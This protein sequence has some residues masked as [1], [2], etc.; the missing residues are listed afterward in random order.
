VSFYNPKVISQ[1]KL[2]DGFVLAWGIASLSLH[3]SMIWKVPEHI[4]Y[5]VVFGYESL[6][7]Y[8]DRILATMN[9][10]QF[11]KQDVADEPGTGHLRI[12]TVG[13][14]IARLYAPGQLLSQHVRVKSVLEARNPDDLLA[15]LRDQNITYVMMDRNS[16]SP[17]MPG[18]LIAQDEPLDEF[19]ELRHAS[20]N[21]VVYRVPAPDAP[22][23]TSIRH[24]LVLDASFEALGESQ[25]PSSSDGSA[26]TVVAWRA[27][28]SP[29]V[30]DSG[31]LSQTGRTAVKVSA[32]NNFTQYVGSLPP[33]RVFELRYSASAATMPSQGQLQ[34]VWTDSAGQMISANAR[35]F[36]ADKNWGTFRM[37]DS[38]PV[39]AAGAI[40]T[41]TAHVGE[42]WVDDVSFS[43]I[44]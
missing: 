19:L 3:A 20:H 36:D 35:V 41:L 1:K 21:I 34:I 2:V 25:E 30:D 42:V 5:A 11:I 9:S 29:A 44:R 27:L 15:A 28:G 10:L 4:P 24:N 39:G 31:A 16:P 33:D 14:E 23:A 43:G 8:L 38:P 6:D 13:S 32:T 7:H 12:Y 40:V 26:S 17:L 18:V 22:A 37:L